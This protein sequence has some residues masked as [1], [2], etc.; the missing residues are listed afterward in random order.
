MI[1]FGAFSF[2]D[3][4]TPLESQGVFVVSTDQSLAGV[5]APK[6]FMSSDQYGAVLSYRRYD[7][8]LSYLT[9]YDDRIFWVPAPNELQVRLGSSGEIAYTQG[10]PKILRKGN[11]DTLDMDYVM[12]WDRM[13]KTHLEVLEELLDANPPL[14]LSPDPLGLTINATSLGMEVDPVRGSPGHY[15]V[16]LSLGVLSAD[17]PGL[18]LLPQAGSDPN[19]SWPR[20]K[21]VNVRAHAVHT[22]GVWVQNKANN[23]PTVIS[24]NIAYPGVGVLAVAFMENIPRVVFMANNKTYATL[25]NSSLI[26]GNQNGHFAQKSFGTGVAVFGYDVLKRKMWGAVSWVDSYGESL[27]EIIEADLP[28]DFSIPDTVILSSPSTFY[29]RPISGRIGWP[30]EMSE[31]LPSYLLTLN[32]EETGSW[33]WA[34]G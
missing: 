12:V 14:V 20:S 23:Q 9:Y 8:V 29:W 2:G 7:Y 10:G 32:L 24:G 6:G 18:L 15:K 17:S 26:V 27:R 22:N 34:R 3:E 19:T 31:G 11:P 13:P 28:Q 25:T 30:Y 5:F 16:T 21:L 1:D 4:Y 33:R